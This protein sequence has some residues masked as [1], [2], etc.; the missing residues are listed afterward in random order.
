MSFII[1]KGTYADIDAIEQ[2]YNELNDVLENGV[3]Y[4]GWIKGVY[5]A[6]EDAVEGIDSGELFVVRNDNIIAGTVILNHKSEEGYKDVKWLNDCDDNNI[7]VIHT[8]AVHPAFFKMGIGR[9]L[10]DFAESFG[11]QNNIKSIRL[12]VYEKNLPAI[13]LYKSSGYQYIA[14]VDLGLG[15]RGLDWF[16]LYEKRL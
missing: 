15:S 8:L 12:D 16:Q 2:L 7:F 4:A 14:T 1:E 13:N 9:Q 6:R 10:L 5:P 3:N 11:R